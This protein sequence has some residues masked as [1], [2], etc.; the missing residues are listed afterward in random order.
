MEEEFMITVGWDDPLPECL[1]S[2]DPVDPVVA[3]MAGGVTW[4]AGVFHNFNDVPIASLA[5][6][7]AFVHIR[8]RLAANKAALETYAADILVLCHF[9]VSHPNSTLRV[10]P[11]PTEVRFPAEQN[12]YLA[13]IVGAIVR[14]HTHHSI[15]ACVGP[16]HQELSEQLKGLCSRLLLQLPEWYPAECHATGVIPWLR[17]QVDDAQLLRHITSTHG[18]AFRTFLCHASNVMLQLQASDAQSNLGEEI[19][20]HNGDALCTE[21]VHIEAARS[22]ITS[23]VNAALKNLR[24]IIF[25]ESN[26]PVKSD[27]D[28]Q[29]CYDQVRNALFA[30]NTSKFSPLACQCDVYAERA[31]GRLYDKFEFDSTEGAA[32]PHVQ[33][34]GVAHGHANTIMVNAFHEK[35][36]NLGCVTVPVYAVAAEDGALELRRR[37]LTKFI[38]NLSFV[39]AML[40]LDRLIED[41]QLELTP[42]M[43]E[44]KE[45]AG[46]AQTYLE[47]SFWAW[48]EDDW[49]RCKE[50]GAL[51]ETYEASKQRVSEEP[52]AV[53]SDRQ[54]MLYSASEHLMLMHEELE[55]KEEKRATIS[56]MVEYARLLYD[57]QCL[58]RLVTA[59]A[60]P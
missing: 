30:L 25:A 18:I 14:Y 20:F 32:P 46:D 39:V 6:A 57:T 3:A 33:L 26:S 60:T 4:L 31:K 58:H 51:T 49:T 29:A 9:L 22:Q 2:V 24:D 45:H 59:A 27:A 16:C 54:L 48:C 53:W 35:K 10:V 23:E 52:D 41:T 43:D 8:G 7:V 13:N 50:S 15:K 21:A 17:K 37:M 19:L 12:V 34:G 1:N 36:A 42:N 44:M 40:A 56:Q 28:A 5:A 11:S 47:G 55:G 38:A